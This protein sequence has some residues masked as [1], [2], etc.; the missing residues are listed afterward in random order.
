MKFSMIYEA[1]VANPTPEEER[2]TLLEM[3]DQAE[4]LDRF[5]FDNIWAVEHTG[6]TQ[7][8]H[9]STPET[10]LAFVAARTKRIGIGHGVVCLMPNMNHPIKVAERIAMLDILSGGRVHF[11][12]GK[13]G[14]QQE[15][16]AFG[17]DLAELQ[18]IIDEAMYLIPKIMTQ[19]EIEH[20]GE[21]IDIPSRPIHP[22]PLQTPHPPIYMATTRPDSLRMAGS[23]G[24]GALVMG[25]G[26]P[27]DIAEKSRV[28]REAWNSRKPEDQVGFR[29]IQH[30]AALCPTIVS[31]DRDLARRVG[32]RGQRFFAEALAHWYQGLPKPTA[33]DLD[34]DEHLAA[35]KQLEQEKFAVIGEDKISLH[36]NHGYFEEVKDAYGTPEDCIAYVQ[37]LLDAGADE[38]LFLS[39]MGGVPHERIMETIEL[40]GTEVIPHFR[41]QQTA[42]AAE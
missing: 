18:P 20:H 8:A 1:Q 5:G 4:A 21:F 19:D 42:Q 23:R 10:F 13:G 24:I 28:Y 37:R 36:T 41:A 30:L 25:F 2:R 27:E 38:I 40:I 31:R 35:L 12:V 3:V 34:A 9:M 11:G 33:Y 15:A 16:G 14:S 22:K 6:L 26:G 17:Y 32:L 7:Y 39:Q 29:P